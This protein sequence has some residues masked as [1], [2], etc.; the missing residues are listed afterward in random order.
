MIKETPNSQ[1]SNN[2]KT[3]AAKTEKLLLT[4]YKHYYYYIK[5]ALIKHLLILLN[6]VNLTETVQIFCSFVVHEEK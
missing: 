3:C 5:H 4:W 2:L 6:S 1:Y